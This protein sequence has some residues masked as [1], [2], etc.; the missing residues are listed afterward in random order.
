[1]GSLSHWHVKYEL[2]KE[3]SAFN[4]MR[5]PRFWD[6]HEVSWRRKQAEKN[7]TSDNWVLTSNLSNEKETHQIMWWR[8]WEWAWAGGGCIDRINLNWGENCEEKNGTVPEEEWWYRRQERMLQRP[9][10]LNEEA[11]S[12]QSLW[13]LCYSTGDTHTLTVMLH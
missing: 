7:R 2:V 8:E 9:P 10:L 5:L 11:F 6:S 13:P 1:M 3:G 4:K 12:F